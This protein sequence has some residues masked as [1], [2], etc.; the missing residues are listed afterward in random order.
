MIKPSS[1]I[2]H[3]VTLVGGEGSH[4]LHLPCFVGF[5]AI[6]SRA[7][8]T[9]S[10]SFSFVRG[11][12]RSVRQTAGKWRASASYAMFEFLAVFAALSVN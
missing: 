10:V 8:S 2:E 3:R 5:V 11:S 4:P 9:E 12:R 7:F 6:C 1:G